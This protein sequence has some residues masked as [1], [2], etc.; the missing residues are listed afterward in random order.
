MVKILNME[1]SGV[2]GQNPNRNLF[3]ANGHHTNHKLR[4][5]KKKKKK[6][7]TGDRQKIRKINFFLR[8]LKL[9]PL[10]GKME[11]LNFPTP[12]LQAAIQ[13]GGL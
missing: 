12:V 6:K 2:N 3:N 8:P 7:K 9:E 10:A 4:A 1:F 11:E 13:K 5:A